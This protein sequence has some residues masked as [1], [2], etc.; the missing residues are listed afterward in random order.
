VS[1]GAPAFTLGVLTPLYL[2]RVLMPQA[3]L[4][5]YELPYEPA[6]AAFRYCIAR[7]E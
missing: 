5:R 1:K 6:A 4:W 2:E 3:E 7:A